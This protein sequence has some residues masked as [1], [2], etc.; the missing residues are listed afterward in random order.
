M[1]KKLREK[2]NAEVKNAPNG[3]I[4]ERIYAFFFASIPAQNG[5]VI[6]IYLFLD[7]F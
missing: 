3:K 7:H 1:K 5:Q 4:L 6:T 2:V